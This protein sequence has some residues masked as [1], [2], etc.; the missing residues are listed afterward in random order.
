MRMSGSHLWPTVTAL[1]ALGLLAGCGGARQQQLERDLRE[2][3]GEVQEL[4]R[5]RTEQRARLEELAGRLLLLQDRLETEQLV[6]RPGPRR[7]Q[8]PVIRLG[9]EESPSEGTYSVL[10]RAASPASPPPGAAPGRRPAP[11][12]PAPSKRPFSVET[13]NHAGID[14][15]ERLARR[16]VPPPASLAPL[17]DPAAPAAPAAVP[18]P[19]PP[20]GAAREPPPAVASAEA[21]LPPGLTS[22]AVPAALTA[23]PARPAPAA[24]RAPQAFPE[25]GPPP[26]AAKDPEQEYKT[27]Y[28][29][30]QAGK[31]GQSRQVFLRFAATYP[32]HDLTDNSLYWL[33]EISYKLHRYEEALQMFGKVIETYPTG[34]KIPDAFLKVG[35]C[36]LNL[37]KGDAARKILQ[38]VRTIFPESPAAQIASS[39]LKL[40]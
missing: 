29:L 10:G 22:G 37:G 20:P 23:A 36:Y 32:D 1:L 5:S 35:L 11:P 33:A 31:F 28:A 2:L 40:L 18:A 8:L 26:R 21:P 34:N 15:G 9:P 12:P 13:A 25:D 30:F 3:Q 17:P 27:A 38:Q 6:A 7:E 39:H 24:T 19:G 14:P 4:K 16:E